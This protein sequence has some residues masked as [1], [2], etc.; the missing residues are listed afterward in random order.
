MAT[1]S[2]N[3]YE[4]SAA[5]IDFQDVLEYYSIRIQESNK[6][7]LTV[8]KG[9]SR[10]MRRPD[11]SSNAMTLGN[12]ILFSRRLRTD[13]SDSSQDRLADMAWLTHE[14]THIWQFQRYHW[15]YLPE[16][17][18]TQAKRG[19]NPYVYSRAISLAGKG[20]DL[21]TMWD[22]GK[23]F[24]DFNREQQGDILADYYRALNSNVNTSGWEPFV[25]EMRAIS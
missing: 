3:P 2:L 16:A 19:S 6:L 25:A 17:I 24:G 21:R 8:A 18:G 5:K 12:T 22:G 9:W 10:L 1:R 7:A 14:L 23:R 15:R 13:P 4:L 20:D 11:P